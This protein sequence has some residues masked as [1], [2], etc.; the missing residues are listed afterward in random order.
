[1]SQN[2]TLCVTALDVKKT[3]QKQLF[4]LLCI[5]QIWRKPFF[6]VQPFYYQLKTFKN[7]RTKLLLLFMLLFLRVSA[8]S[9]II[10]GD[11]MMCPFTDGTVSVTGSTVYDSYQW[12]YKYWFLPGDFVAIDGAT[13]DTFTYDWYTYDQSLFKVVVTLDGVTYES[14]TI[15]I[16]SYAWTGMTVMTELNDSVTFDPNTEG[17]LLC[18]GGSFDLTVNSP[19]DVVF[20]YKDGELIDGATSSTYTITEAGEYYAVAAPSFCPDNT[21]TS[22][23]FIVSMTECS[24]TPVVAPVIEGDV[25]LCP[26]TDGT[27][28]VIG[29][30]IYDS[31]QW[32]YKYWFLEDDFEA[33]DGATEATFTYDWFTYDQALLKVVVTLDGVTYESNTI[34]VDSYNWAGLLLSYDLGDNVTFDPDTEIFSLCE[35]T[36]FELTVNNPPYEVINWYKDGVLIEGANEATYTITEPGVYLVEAAPSFCPDSTNTIEMTVVGVDCELNTNNPQN[37]LQ[38]SVYPNPTQDNINITIANFAEPVSYTITDITGK[39]VM[40]GTFD[41]AENT[42]A[43]GGLTLGLYFVKVSSGYFT[44]FVKVI[45][46]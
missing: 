36:E 46:N 17:Y 7:M 3:L 20:W 38:M 33:I 18:N 14:N 22:L 32:Y 15:Q 30:T 39:T 37:N 24:E 11:T 9:P 2:V 41:Q 5:T 26:Y 40:S 8:Q 45:K 1:M 31:Y 4:P 23:P 6:C 28:S 34:Q 42:V 12:Y 10:E 13:S 27:V 25:M 44:E 19:Y 35:G 16:D 29:S 43:L 21:S